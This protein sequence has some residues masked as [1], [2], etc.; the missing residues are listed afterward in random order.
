MS[1]TIRQIV[2]AALTVVGE[3]TGTPGVQFYEEPRMLDDANRA[4][5]MIFKK[6][7]WEQYLQWFTVTLDGTTGKI[8]TN[9][10]TN[11]ADFED[12]IAV[13]RDKESSRLPVAPKRLN[14]SSLGSTT[15]VL[16]WTSL[17]ATDA[18]YAGR[19]LQ[20]YPVTAVGNVNVLARVYPVTPP[21]TLQFTDTVYLDKDMM[22]YA[23]A[24]MTLS[25]DDLNAGAAE[26]VRNLMEMK[27]KDITAQL[28][29]HPLPIQGDSGIPMRWFVT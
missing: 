2:D 11:I 17:N 29:N 9:A 1:A 25:G 5:N 22:A 4:F 3:V 15:R 18:N 14:P 7:T 8:T 24:F 13:H 23:T 21:A 20:F 12:F 28:G 26:V 10:F 6:Y 19:K 16:Y 27:Y